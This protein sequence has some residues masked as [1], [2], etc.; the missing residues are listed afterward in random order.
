MRIAV[1]EKISDQNLSDFSNYLTELLREK[2]IQ[3]GF[4]VK[5]WSNVVPAISQHFAAKSMVL[6][7]QHKDSGISHWWYDK[8]KLPGIIKRIKPSVII[9]LN[10]APLTLN[11]IPGMLAVEAIETVQKKLQNIQS[12][13]DN[14]L[15]LLTFSD[16]MVNKLK[17]I[18]ANK[19]VVVEKIKYSAPYQ[20]HA[21]D[22]LDKI[23]IKSRYAD[24]KEYFTCIINDDDE[25]AFLT[26]LKAFSKFKKWQQSA[27]QLLVMPKFET[28]SNR[29]ADKLANYKYRRDVQILNMLSTKETAEVI[30][31]AYAFI[32]VP[33]NAADL[34]PAIMAL[35]C[36]T[37]VIT[38]ENDHSREYCGEA[39][40][41]VVNNNFEELGD[42]IIK[43]Y[44][45]ENLR[46]TLADA[47]NIEAKFFDRQ[48][49]A[50]DLWTIVEKLSTQSE[51]K[52]K[53]E[54]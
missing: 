16:N 25:T 5:G 28:L 21:L 1:I 49:I 12:K 42:Q 35:Q 26:I 27:M 22:M 44:K 29:L 48:D 20:F 18:L 46:A 36:A 7:N 9:Y 13:T 8:I 50:N 39:A 15:I 52:N 23:M 11:A 54:P 34:L 33:S 10:K 37:P 6:I 47:C 31:T 19:N 53:L 17:T 4:E 51:I 2:A 32:H 43:I 30:A 41:Y 14:K 40:L 38:Y 24:N 3:T 45:D